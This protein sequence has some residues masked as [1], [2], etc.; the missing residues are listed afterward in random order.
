M[1]ELITTTKSESKAII[2]NLSDFAR[3][4][5]DKVFA[6]SE[7]V[8]KAA[9]S[10]NDAMLTFEPQLCDSF[11][12]IAADK[13]GIK[14]AGFDNFTAFA[15]AAFGINDKAAS[16]YKRVGDKF[17]NVKDRPTCAAWYTASK[18]Q[19]LR[20]VDNARLDKDAADG[21]LRPDMTLSALRE[22]AT[23]VKAESITDGAQAV[24]NGFC[25]VVLS[26]MEKFTVAAE[27]EIYALLNDGETPL[28]DNI[29]TTESAATII[30][31]AKDEKHKDK[32]IKTRLCIVEMKDGS[33][34]AARFWKNP[35]ILTKEE[36]AQAEVIRASLEK[37]GIDT[38]SMTARQLLDASIK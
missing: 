6:L 24:T 23:A 17:F 12:K 11:S 28:A 32:E 9:K 22:Y 26:S 21:I 10:V 18:L 36:R 2:K 29:H 7:T 38:S 8:D 16:M 19:E 5:C 20:N 14:K 34:R 30:I 35:D 15:A 25:G 3:I 4:E 13:D 1:N 33:I 37:F 27:S 31:P